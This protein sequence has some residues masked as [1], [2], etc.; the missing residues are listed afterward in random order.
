MTRQIEYQ[1]RMR[2]QGRCRV[3]GKKAN[4]AFCTKHALAH[5]TRSRNWRRKKAGIP[6][7]A[8]VAKTRPRKY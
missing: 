1:K 7:D 3:C 2:A 6:L 5:R 4:G 8:P